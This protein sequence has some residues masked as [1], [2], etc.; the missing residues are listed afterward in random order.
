M[1]ELREAIEKQAI[2]IGTDIVRVDMF[3]NHKLDTALMRKIG[4]T[5]HQAFE[6]DPVDIILTAESSGIVVAFATAQAFGDLPVVVAKKG[7]AS[8]LAQADVYQSRV[9]SFTHQQEN[10]VYV[11]KAY[12]QEGSRVLIIDDFLANGEAAHG[13]VDIVCQA[14]AQ[15]VGV[16]VCIEKG[17]QSGGATLRSEGYKVVALATVTGIQDG[18]PVLAEEE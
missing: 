4:Q 16:G 18:K 11:N 15:V 12:L 1:R 9:Y 3:L 7:K 5:L 13:L 10:T 6:K 17:F 8:T 14:K 2:G